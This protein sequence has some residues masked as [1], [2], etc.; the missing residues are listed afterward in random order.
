MGTALAPEMSLYGI[1]WLPFFDDDGNALVIVVTAA[2][3]FIRLVPQEFAGFGRI[4]FVSNAA[5]T[6]GPLTLTLILRAE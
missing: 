5:E 6:G 1:T 4:R 2:A 3:R